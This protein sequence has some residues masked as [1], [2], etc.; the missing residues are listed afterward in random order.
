MENGRDGVAAY[1]TEG[2]GGEKKLSYQ[3]S[4]LI[5]FV[6]LRGKN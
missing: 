6:I 1:L 3:F 5:F 2:K 4:I